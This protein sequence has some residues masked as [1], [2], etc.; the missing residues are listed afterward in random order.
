M[1]K[2]NI[3]MLCLQKCISELLDMLVACDARDVH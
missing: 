2:G 3:I 1:K